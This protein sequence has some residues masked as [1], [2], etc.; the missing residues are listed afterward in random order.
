MQSHD[1]LRKAAP[2]IL[3]SYKKL[4]DTEEYDNF[5][6]T[7]FQTAFNAVKFVMPE[8]G[9][10]FDTKLAALPEIIKLPYE[11]IV[12]EYECTNKGGLSEEHFGATKVAPARKRIV[13]AS[14]R[15]DV[16]TVV[17]MVCFN[18]NLIERW[19]IQPYLACVLTNAKEEDYLKND[20]LEKVFGDKVRGNN[21]IENLGVYFYDICGLAEKHFGGRWEE[22]AYCDMMDE[23]NSIM[24]LIEALSCKNVGIE[25]LPRRKMNKGAMKRGALPFNDYHVLTV[26]GQPKSAEAYGDAHHRSPREHL[27]RGHIRRLLTGNTWVNSTVVNAGIGS[28][29]IKTYALETQ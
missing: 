20:E 26:T 28:K 23:C 2:S 7:I 8:N 17:S 22:N 3:G 29:I 25:T 10:I 13:I 9:K 5:V 4:C 16:I 1:Y 12:V 14:Q 11:S 21:V 18:V 15:G 24:G 19:Q 27:R 6:K